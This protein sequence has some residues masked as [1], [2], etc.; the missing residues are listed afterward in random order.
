MC[1]SIVLVL[2]LANVCVC[3]CECA[4][5][6]AMLAIKLQTLHTLVVLLCV[7]CWYYGTTIYATMYSK[8][9]HHL[10]INESF[11]KMYV[12]FCGIVC[13]CCRC[14]T[15]AVQRMH[16]I[17]FEW[18]ALSMMIIIVRAC[19]WIFVLHVLQSWF[20]WT[21]T[22]TTTRQGVCLCQGI[23]L[24]ANDHLKIRSDGLFRTTV[25]MVSIALIL[26]YSKHP[27]MQ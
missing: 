2:E 3:V 4:E 15:I 9:G 24:F 21:K 16:S 20:W 10:H 7:S 11:A 13:V 19:F 27:E 1:S 14:D 22:A 12:H 17:Y 8:V 5:A 18:F 23:N 25:R 6:Y 26:L